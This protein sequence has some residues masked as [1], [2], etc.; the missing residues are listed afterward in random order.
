MTSADGVRLDPTQVAALY[1]RHADEL[2][3]FL[4]GVV[5]DG[6]LATEALQIAFAKAVEVGHTVQEDSLKSWLYRVAYN[7]ALAIRRRQTVGRRVQEKLAERK[8]ATAPSLK[9]AL[10]ETHLS[11]WETVAAVRKALEKLPEEQNRVVRMRI[12]EHKKFAEIAEEL[13]LPLGTV[14]SRMQLALKKLR[15]LLGDQAEFNS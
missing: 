4:L 12:Y 13:N 1:V 7:E 9:D 14:L 3:Y 2:R 6:E 11:R 5:R 10:P 8:Q 15:R